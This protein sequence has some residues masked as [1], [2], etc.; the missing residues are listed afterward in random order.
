MGRSETRFA[1][2]RLALTNYL[3]HSLIC[4]TI[5]YGYGLGLF[6][7]VN[8]TGLV[9][10]V[11]AIWVLQLIV[12]PIWLAHFRFGPAEWVW[13]SLTYWRLQPTRRTAPAPLL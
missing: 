12:S 5:F 4:T 11:L 8:R 9:G 7:T 13:R 2:W 3:M 10:V 1:R 6:G